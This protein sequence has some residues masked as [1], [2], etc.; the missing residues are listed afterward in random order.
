M[1]D[2]AIAR[3][4]VISG[5]VQGVWYRDSTRQEAERLGAAGWVRN[6][7]DGR[8]ELHA[9]GPADAVDALLA[10]CAEGPPLAHV[11]SVDADEAAPEG[12]TSFE[13]R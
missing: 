1:N 3:R 4:A 11:V 13:I 8:V 5:L 7:P 2:E 6:L 9:E 12:A 10:W